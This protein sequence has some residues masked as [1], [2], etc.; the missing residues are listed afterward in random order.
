LTDPEF[1]LRIKD[2]LESGMLNADNVNLIRNGRYFGIGRSF[3]LIVGRNQP[4]NQ[5]LMNCVREG[6]L[7]IEPETKGPTAL[8]RGEIE[9]KYM[10]IS[11]KI[12][13]HYC[14]SAGRKTQIN[15]RIFPRDKKSITVTDDMSGNC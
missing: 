14:R 5:T 4:E 13:A 2:L 11:L 7:I 15:F 12:T 10:K 1:S 9:E 8:A 3:K 6:D